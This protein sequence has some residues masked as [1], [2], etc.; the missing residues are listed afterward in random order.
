M[1][2][3]SDRVVARTNIKARENVGY[4]IIVV[5]T[6]A[7]ASFGCLVCFLLCV[8]SWV[9]ILTSIEFVSVERVDVVIML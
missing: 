1:E 2:G 6:C 7:V 4:D 9:S 3:E 5:V 8:F